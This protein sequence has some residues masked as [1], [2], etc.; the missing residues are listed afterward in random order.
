MGWRLRS[1]ETDSAECGVESDWTRSRF[2]HSPGMETVLQR[3]HE[4]EPI[5]IL[6]LG[7]SVGANIEYLSAFAHHIRVADLLAEGDRVDDAED[8]EDH[9]AE[10]DA[11]QMIPSRWGSFDLVFVWDV[12]DYLSEIRLRAIA[13]RL[14]EVCDLD[15]RLFVT[16]STT[17]YMPDNPLEHTIVDRSTLSLAARGP[18]RKKS[19]QWPPALIDRVLRGFSVERSF[20]LR[21]GLQE[22]VAVRK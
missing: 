19:P 4:E 18:G 1:S 21:C 17:E 5:R 20:V 7:P 9:Q 22:F 3:L 8:L 12:F 2:R 14:W 16:V 10:A 13:G 6:D 15:A 11:Q